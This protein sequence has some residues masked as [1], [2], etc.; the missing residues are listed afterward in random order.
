MNFTAHLICGLLALLIGAALFWFPNN[1]K[2]AD[3]GHVTDWVLWLSTLFL[4]TCGAW[5]VA[6]AFRLTE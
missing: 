1:G 5:V 6:F 2:P 3:P 4:M